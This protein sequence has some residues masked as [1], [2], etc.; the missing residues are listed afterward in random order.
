MS[1]VDTVC[2]VLPARALVVPEMFLRC[3]L[4]HCHVSHRPRQKGQSQVLD[5][6]LSFWL[7]RSENYRRG[8]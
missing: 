7:N 8:R 2:S 5:G 3:S 1:E 6:S 4:T